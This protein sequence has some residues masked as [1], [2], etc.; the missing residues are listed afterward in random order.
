MKPVS[1]EEGIELDKTLT[2]R[3]IAQ[4]SGVSAATVSR[5]LNNTANI[6]NEKKKKIEKIIN[7][8]GYVPNQLARGLSKN[9]ANAVCVIVPDIGNSFFW[10]VI[11]GIN[12][13]L[14]PLGLRIILY[15]TAENQEKEMEFLSR[16]RKFDA[17]GIIIT[18][19]SDTNEFNFDYLESFK[20][21]GIPIVLVDRDVKHSNFDGVFIDNIKASFDAT[22]ELL[23]QGHKEIG[24]I[25][26]PKTSKPGRDRLTGYY[27]AF[28]AKAVNLNE[29]NIY[30]GDFSYESGY[31]L[32]KQLLS[33]NK[34]ITAIF[35][36]NNLM[37]LGAL[38]AI[39]ELG[40]SIPDDISFMAFDEISVLSDVGYDISYVSRETFNMGEIAGEMLLKR[41]S[42][43]EDLSITR[44]ILSATLVLNGS[45]RKMI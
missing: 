25:S 3:D 38:K 35:T 31:K 15:D 21:V 13:V 24:I 18:P 32:T 19:V 33:Q 7:Q 17:C 37:T 20:R 4:L 9:Q 27:E 40:M 29:D 6:K 42:G 41:L 2:I 8:Y 30:M 28:K 22:M 5:Y 14:D 16:I 11:K 23:H 36:C 12:S 10:D 34:K 43:P 39:N 45:E 44:T 26:G 1:F